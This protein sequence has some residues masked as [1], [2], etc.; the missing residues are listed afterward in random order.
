[1]LLA[2]LQEQ[3]DELVARDPQVRRDLP[4]ALHKMRV[5]TRRLRSALQTFR[6]LLDRERTDPLREELRWL[7]GVLGEVRD[8]EVMHARLRALVAAEPPSWSSARC[9]RGST[10]SS[11]RATGPRT[12]ECSPSSTAR[13]TSRC[14]TPSTPCWPTRRCSRS[15]A[16]G[17]ARSCPAWSGTPTAAVQGA[18]ARRAGVRPERDLL[19][20][21]ARKDA[22]RARYAAEAVASAYGKP[23]MR[24][25]S[26]S[27]GCRR[28][29]AST[30]TVW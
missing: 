9:R 10:P 25:A 26:Q 7:A 14:S 22:K 30:R 5:A 2:H 20:H 29:S 3:V 8:T 21:E 27:R 4:D 17:P 24:F 16:S 11:R 23:A 19:L 1:M 6:P 18:A 12:T 28:C 15:P 13:A